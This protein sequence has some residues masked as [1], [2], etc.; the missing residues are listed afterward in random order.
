MFLKRLCLEEKV[1]FLEL[2]YYVANIDNDFSV[3]EQEMI[4]SYCQEMEISDIKYDQ[5][6]FDLSKVL[7]TFTNKQSQKIVLLE[8]FALI[9]SDLSIDI[10]ETTIINKIIETFELDSQL[11]IVYE[12]WAKAVLAIYAQGEALVTL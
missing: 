11:V 7:A 10:E 5:N 12:Q 8:I 3:I 4:K 6:L 2:A 1:A 9:H